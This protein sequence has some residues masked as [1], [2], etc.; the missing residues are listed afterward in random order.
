MCLR[1]IEGF[2]L[3]QDLRQR[4]VPQDLPTPRTGCKREGPL[5]TVFPDLL[6]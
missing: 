3:F 1:E 2:R 6:L 4:V 5:T